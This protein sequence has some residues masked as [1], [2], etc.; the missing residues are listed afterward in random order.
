[1]QQR[2]ASIHNQSQA[3]GP[4]E[5][6]RDY[7]NPKDELGIS[8]NIPDESKFLR[9]RALRAQ[10]NDRTRSGHVRVVPNPFARLWR[11]A[12]QVVFELPE[13]VSQTSFLPASKSQQTPVSIEGTPSCMFVRTMQMS[14]LYRAPANYQSS[15]QETMGRASWAETISQ[16]SLYFFPN[17]HQ[18]LGCSKV[19]P[20]QE[21]YLPQLRKHQRFG[22]K[23]S[24]SR[25]REILIAHEQRSSELNSRS[26]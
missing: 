8:S 1:M 17:V 12:S 25:R 4:L 7:E 13:L 6:P 15:L 22:L 3:H 9:V 10:V 24:V 14:T 23:L 19:L 2:A 11:A 26:G 20:I 16:E 18:H 21:D 5:V